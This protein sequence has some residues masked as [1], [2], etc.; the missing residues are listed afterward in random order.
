M[1]S[2]ITSVSDITYISEVILDTK[3]TTIKLNL[4]CQGLIRPYNLRSVSYGLIK[5]GCYVTR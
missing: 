3:P 5:R 2:K 4:T 1:E